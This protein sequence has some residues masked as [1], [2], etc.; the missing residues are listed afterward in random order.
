MRDYI[1]DTR[2]WKNMCVCVLS[3]S[4]V[5]RV[6]TR[7]PGVQFKSVA[8]CCIVIYQRAGRQFDTKI[9]RIHGHPP[10]DLAYFAIN[11]ETFQCIYNNIYFSKTKY[12]SPV[13]RK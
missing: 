8:M 2:T 7:E 3:V 5:Q 1:L 13:E 10:S 9:G 6:F 4:G 11:L 12:A